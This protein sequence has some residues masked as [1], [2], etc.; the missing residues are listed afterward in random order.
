[1][2]TDE[3]AVGVDPLFRSHSPL[4]VFPQVFL[5]VDVVSLSLEIYHASQTSSS[6]F[7]SFPKQGNRTKPPTT[8]CIQLC[9]TFGR[10][11]STHIIINFTN[12]GYPFSIVHAHVPLVTFH[13]AA[14]TSMAT[15]MPGHFYTLNWHS[16]CAQTSAS[17]SIVLRC[18][19]VAGDIN[20][21]VSPLT[22]QA[23]LSTSTRKTLQ[24]HR[25]V[26]PAGHLDLII[27][28]S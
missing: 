11:A 6:Y 3:S 20:T 23:S 12:N 27:S 13:G 15:R 22:S 14:H 7:C 24:A 10:P 28:I 21:Q 9:H 25:Q 26:S 16:F 18:I 19:N 5:D 17:C 8:L 1:M 2:I 4:E